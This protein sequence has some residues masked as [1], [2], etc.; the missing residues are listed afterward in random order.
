MTRTLDLAA[1]FMARWPLIF[2]FD[3]ARYLIAAGLAAAALHLLARR[4]EARRIRAGT[5]PRCP[6]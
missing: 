6:R 5:P 2:A 1:E 3:L 4:L